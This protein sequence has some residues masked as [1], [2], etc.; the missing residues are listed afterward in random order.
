ML[1]EVLL[2][3]RQSTS[4]LSRNVSTELQLVLTSVVADTE[5]VDVSSVK[6]AAAG[7]SS[8]TYVNVSIQNWHTSEAVV[9]PVTGITAVT[10]VAGVNVIVEVLVALIVKVGVACIVV[11]VE[12]G[13]TCCPAQAVVSSTSTSA[14]NK[15]KREIFCIL[16]FPFFQIL[17][18]HEG[19][20]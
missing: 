20:V 5:A 13:D 3:A 1:R 2:G 4:C 6:V 9:G 17:C 14:P 18:G 11:A 12:V 10:V 16:S 15:N 19:D 7:M 8:S